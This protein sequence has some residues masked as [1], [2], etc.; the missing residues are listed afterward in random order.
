MFDTGAGVSSSN[1]L[2]LELTR[3]TGTYEQQLIVGYDYDLGP[4]N[5]GNYYVGPGDINSGVDRTR[6]WHEFTIDSTP[7]SLMFYID[8]ILV[9]TEPNG[10]AFDHLYLTMFAPAF[11]PAWTGYFDDVSFVEY[12]PT[13][14]P[15][16]TS[17]VVFG[18]GVVGVLGAVLR[19]RA[20]PARVG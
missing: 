7:N 3:L 9:R 14:T 15:E 10:F 5:G 2:A 16:P 11:R 6:T 19:R 8:G 18:L 12:A 20:T 17:A 4:A 13:P 1:Y